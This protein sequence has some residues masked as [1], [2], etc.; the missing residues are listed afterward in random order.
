[1]PTNISN[2]LTLPPLFMV[3]QNFEVPPQLDI[4]AAVD[5]EWD[6]LRSSL[7]VLPAARVAVGVGSRGVDNLALVTRK[8]VDKL[9]Q[10]GAEPFVIPAMGSHGGATAAG[11]IEVL[12]ERGV[13]EQSVGAPIEATM[14]TVFLG[15]SDEGIPLFLDRL[16]HDADGIVLINRV[17]LLTPAFQ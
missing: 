4:A 13:T 14:E 2:T 15:T 9:R 12:A 3:R 17:L 10:V 6:R 7:D 11:Q 16:A 8:V 5:A 1:M